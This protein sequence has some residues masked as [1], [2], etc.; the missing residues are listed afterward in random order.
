MM[1]S[2]KRYLL[3]VAVLL[4]GYGLR[5][6]LLADTNYNWDEG[7]SAWISGLPVA[8][9]AD[10]T[11]RDVH[12]PLYYLLL[13][14]SRTLLLGDTEFILRYTSLI[15][16]MLLIA[17][18]YRFGR[19][20]GGVGVGITA[21]LLI[22]AARGHVHIS[23][24]ARM[25]ALAA[26][27][28][29]VALWLALI[30]WRNPRDWRS[31]L[32]YVLSTAG[33]LYTFY[34]TIML[35]LAVNAAVGVLLLIDHQR[36]MWRKLLAWAGL[37]I[38]A[39]LLFVP[40]IAYALPRMFSWR[41]DQ[42]TP[43][44][45]FTQFYLA[46]L[47]VGRPTFDP[48]QL[49]YVFAYGLVVIVGAVW[50]L[51]TRRSAAVLLVA[52]VVTPAVVVFLLALPF[53]NWGRPLAAR[54]LLMLSACFY[55]LAAL[56]IHGLT[57]WRPAA[58]RI[59]WLVPL[60]V[61]TW[62]LSNIAQG[63][64]RRDD[65][66]SITRLLEAMR[67]PDDA[68]ILHNDWT[69]TSLAAHYNGDFARIP[70]AEP[71]HRSY[72]RLLLEP[73]RDGHDRV[74]VIRT[75]YAP[76]NDPTGIVNDWL[77]DRSIAA[78]EWTFND[79]TLTAYTIRPPRAVSQ[80]D[81]APGFAPPT[82]HAAPSIG[83][84][85]VERVFYRFPIGD[86]VYAA[87]YWEH[88]PDAPF[89]VG[90]THQNGQTFTHTIQP[91]PPARGITRQQIAVPLLPDYPTG[92]YDLWLALENQRV[93]LGRLRADAVRNSYT[94]EAGDIQHTTDMRFGESIALMG[95]TLGRDSVRSGGD[96][97]VTLYWQT[98]TALTTRYKVS[99]FLLGTA[100]NPQT[101]NP[102]WGQIDAEP[103]NWT[104]PT[105]LWQTSTLIADPYTV[106]V[107]SSAPA[108]DYTL[109]V[110]L[111]NTVTGERLLTADGTDYAAIHTI[112]IR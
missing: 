54:Y 105:T 60:I 104:L 76:T 85:G 33:A 89:R 53:H 43:P 23:Q 95:Y 103:Q 46:T 109:G 7:Y 98:D 88:V 5:V 30:W 6:W 51:R 97:D 80:Y 91:P 82:T 64:V 37:Q 12:P 66:H 2:L 36:G 17:I 9:L 92:H 110:V 100:F 4:L 70:V 27:W 10:T 52:G 86:S 29:T 99:V 35:P 65:L 63:A 47:T 77:L 78:H 79:H 90:I 57:R 73:Y 45:F 84:I 22:A 49:P 59:A 24:L 111:Y 31:A 19:A 32:G 96:L 13:K 16:G 69:W 39:A 1:T 38:A 34:L 40:W 3:V 18:T 56:G 48:Q 74:W 94:V 11:A 26:L 67:H 44:G 62:G 71:L 14:L 83:L 81:L 20:V 42:I 58:G 50:G 68:L 87:L 101:N 107:A 25:H 55:V 61:A 93:A 106:P 72:A 15:T 108:G 75:P 41:S 102:L 112:R 28:S 8:Q 21:A